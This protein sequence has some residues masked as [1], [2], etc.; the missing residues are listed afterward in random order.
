MLN[1]PPEEED[2]ETEE[3]VVEEQPEI[4]VDDLI[5]T[6]G[7]WVCEDSIFVPK[8]LLEYNYGRLILG[9]VCLFGLA[10]PTNS[11]ELN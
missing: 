10:S 1:K 3:K 6:P 8:T 9:S 5:K 4:I 7:G 2:E 11:S